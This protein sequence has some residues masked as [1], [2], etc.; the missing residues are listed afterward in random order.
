MTVRT[1]VPRTASVVS[2]TCGNLQHVRLFR[3]DQGCGQGG[4]GVSDAP[5]AIFSICWRNIARAALYFGSIPSEIAGCRS[6]KFSSGH[7]SH[8]LRPQMARAYCLR[9]QP[10][11]HRSRADRKHRGQGRGPRNSRL[12]RS[13]GGICTTATVQPAIRRQEDRAEA[14][15]SPENCKA[16]RRPACTPGSAANAIWLVWQQHLV[17]AK[18][19]QRQR[20]GVAAAA[21]T[22][23]EDPA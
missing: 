6:G 14:A 9:Y 13:A 16:T 21:F 20:D 5:C 11:D 3:V 8:S 15:T 7:H 4:N 22:T 10:P 2:L 19:I 23:P 17:K 18:K 12:H 1:I